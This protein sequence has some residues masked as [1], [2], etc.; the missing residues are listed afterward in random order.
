MRTVKRCLTDITEFPP[1]R[2]YPHPTG[3]WNWADAKL[4]LNT[5]LCKFVVC[6]LEAD[7][8]SSKIF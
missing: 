2:D 5:I 8:K 4:A 7:R 1:A 6:K 3:Q